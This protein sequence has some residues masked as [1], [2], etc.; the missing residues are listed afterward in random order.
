MFE[1]LFNLIRDDKAS[2]NLFDRRD[3]SSVFLVLEKK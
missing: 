1:I 3:N 2:W